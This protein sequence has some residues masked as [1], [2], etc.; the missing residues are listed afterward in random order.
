MHVFQPVAGG[1]PAYAH[2]LALALRDRG[3]EVTVACDPAAAVAADLRRQGVRVEPLVAARRPAAGDAGA[4]RALAA[5][6]RRAR[7]DVIHA[8]SSKAGL[9]AG[10]AGR[11]LRVPT[12]YTPHGWSFQMDGP[13]PVRAA[14]A[15]AESLLARAAHRRVVAVCASE[16]REALRRH[17]AAADHIAVVRTGWAGH[18][19]DKPD[20]RAA[21]AALGIGGDAPVA[22]WIGR[23]GPQKG[24]D[25]LPALAARLADGG[26]VLVALGDGL[27]ASGIADAIADAGGIAVPPGLAP[28]ELLAAADVLVSTSAWEGLPL[29][30]LEA[31][32]HALPVVAFDVGGLPE[33]V[34]EGRTGYLVPRGAT[35][36]LAER[37]VALVRDPVAAHR[38]GLAGRA[39][40]SE[41]FQPAVMVDRIELIYR[42]VIDQ[43]RR[44]T[45][46]P[47]DAPTTIAMN[48]A[49]CM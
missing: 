26:V 42:D 23:T 15:V 1:V 31:L 28:C 7:P 10:I 14:F 35:N 48:T 37:T 43:G 16:R 32:E 3:W 6:V 11:A 13:G 19:G 8:H 39:L 41:R 12:V 46:T 25:G 47:A 49:T 44:S 36:A 21:R 2:D 34:V 45:P 27:Q 38:L 17:V 22:A 24:A 20:R 9:L 18:A 30:V 40:W 5:H 33:Q 4:L 29:V